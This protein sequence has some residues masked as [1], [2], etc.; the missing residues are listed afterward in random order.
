MN[1]PGLLRARIIYSLAVLAFT[2]PNARA[3]HGAGVVAAI[4][5]DYAKSLAEWRP[6]AW[7]W[8]RSPAILWVKDDAS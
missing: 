1:R 8:F 2:A 5:Q 7:T 6:L 3:D 4:N